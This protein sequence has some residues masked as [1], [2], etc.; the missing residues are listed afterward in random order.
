MVKNRSRLGNNI[1]NN[2]ALNSKCAVRYRQ[3]TEKRN[4]SKQIVDRVRTSPPLKMAVFWDAEPC[5]LEAV[6]SSETSV[7]T[8][9]TTWWYIPE[10]SR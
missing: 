9:Q 5:N 1:V 3:Q 2:A 4:Y 6:S 10:D 8:Y 7:I